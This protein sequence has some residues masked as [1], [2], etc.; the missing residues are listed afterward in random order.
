LVQRGVAGDDSWYSKPQKKHLV[1]G[2]IEH[3]YTFYLIPVEKC[4][5]ELFLKLSKQFGK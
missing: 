3:T 2:S 5:K 4:S 1:N